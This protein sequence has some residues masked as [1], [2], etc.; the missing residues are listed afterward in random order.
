MKSTDYY[1][2]FYD[3]SDS[4]SNTLYN[5]IMSSFKTNHANEKIYI[6][7]LSKGFAAS[8]IAD[9]SNPSVQRIEDLKVKGPT[10]IKISNGQNVAYVEGKES[11]IE[12]LK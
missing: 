2:L 6:V 1:V 4:S 5:G 11:I 8:Y 12:I 10:V 3:F 7:D 9:T